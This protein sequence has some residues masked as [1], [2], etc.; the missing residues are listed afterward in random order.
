MSFCAT[1]KRGVSMHSNNHAGIS[2]AAMTHLGAS[3]P[4]L[5][6]ALDTHYPWQSEEVLTGGRFVFEDGS[7]PVP[8]GP[9]LGIELDRAALAVLH[10][11]YLACGLPVVTTRVPLLM[12]LVQDCPAVR[13]CPETAGE[14]EAALDALASGEDRSDLSETARMFSD[15][16]FNC[17]QE[18]QRL[19]DL[20]RR[21]LV[22]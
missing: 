14:Y 5:S 19:A 20:Y 10:A 16:R 18:A 1:F 11:N 8:T 9:G 17:G 15:T 21:I 12:E 3:M 2:L 6:H 13:I 7:L 22:E 4:N